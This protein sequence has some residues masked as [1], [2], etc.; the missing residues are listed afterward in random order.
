MCSVH[1]RYNRFIH[2]SEHDTSPTGLERHL[3]FPATSALLW[4]AAIRL[5]QCPV[6]AKQYNTSA[7]HS[8]W[9]MRQTSVWYGYTPHMGVAH[10]SINPLPALMYQNV[11]DLNDACRAKRTQTYWHVRKFKCPLNK[12]Q[13]S[14]PCS[15]DLNWT[16]KG[17][18]CKC[19]ASQRNHHHHYLWSWNLLCSHNLCAI[20]SHSDITQQSKRWGNM[21]SQWPRKYRISRPIRCTFLP[22]KM[23]PK[24]DLRL[25]RQG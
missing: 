11:L 12:T 21:W 14:C 25:I 4:V 9:Y 6:P 5:T 8:H 7:S 10:L 24:F 2:P 3:D 19:N 13:P 22:E 20:L 18:T 15:R 17:L 23:W 1:N 16:G